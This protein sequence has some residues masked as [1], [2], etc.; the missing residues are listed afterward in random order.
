MQKSTIELL[1][2]MGRIDMDKCTSREGLTIGKVVGQCSPRLAAGGSIEDSSV[3]WAPV[4]FSD[5]N[6]H[7]SEPRR[8]SADTPLLKNNCN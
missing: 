8:E 2:V 3:T 5:K 1:S 6:Q 4:T 7:L